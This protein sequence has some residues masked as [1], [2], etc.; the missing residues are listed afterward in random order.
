MIEDNISYASTNA[1]MYSWIY[2]G[3]HAEIVRRYSKV[4]QRGAEGDIKGAQDAYFEL[5]KYVSDNEL[6]FH[7]V[8]DGFLF[9][10]ALRRKI[11]LPAVPY[12]D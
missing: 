12:Y 3:Y 7:R 6:T 1:E 10:R 9:L 4:L 11:D 2:L 5:E 8:F